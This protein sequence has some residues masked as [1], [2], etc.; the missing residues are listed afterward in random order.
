MKN[1]NDIL[2]EIP[3]LK[4][5]LRKPLTRQQTRI[6]AAAAEIAQ[7]TPDEIEPAFMARQLVQATLP[8][9]NPGNVPA[10]TR[11][12]GD[13]KL[14]VQAGWDETRD[15]TIGYPYGTLPRLLLFWITTEA[16]RTGQ[17]RLELGNS[18]AAFMRELGLD[19]SRG[20]KRSDARRLRDQMERLFAARISFTQEKREGANRGKAWLRMSVAPRGVMWWDERNPEQPCLFRSWIQLSAEFFEAIRSAPVPVNMQALRA[21]K[22]SALALDLY[23]WASYTAYIATQT[24]KARF[25]SWELLMEQF[26]GGYAH[27]QHFRAKAKAALRKIKVV[28]PGLSIGKAQGGIEILPG[29]SAAVPPRKLTKRKAD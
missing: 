10:W 18:L 4:R 22:G 24:G 8:H 2:D 28:Y 23:A 15:R 7:Q 25:V 16:I 11:K 17:P 20:G 29:A 3:A 21:L 9:K 5:D 19:P 14:T 6:I 27:V 1:I 13:L 26:G 12:N